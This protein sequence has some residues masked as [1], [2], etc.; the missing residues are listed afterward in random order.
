MS[1]RKRL[2]KFCSATYSPL[3]VRER[4]TGWDEDILS[5]YSNRR[6]HLFKAN[7]LQKNKHT[8]ENTCCIWCGNDIAWLHGL[9]SVQYFYELGRFTCGTG[10]I[11]ET[12]VKTRLIRDGTPT[13]SI[14]CQYYYLQHHVYCQMIQAVKTKYY[15]LKKCARQ[16][17]YPS[18]TRCLYVNS[19]NVDTGWISEIVLKHTPEL[20]TDMEY[21]GLR[22][23]FN[24][25]HSK[26]LECKRKQWGN[27]YA[28]QI[29]NIAVEWYN[30]FAGLNLNHGYSDISSRDGVIH[31]LTRTYK[32]GLSF[33]YNR[34]HF[35]TVNEFYLSKVQSLH[36]KKSSNREKVKIWVPSRTKNNDGKYCEQ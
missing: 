11:F 18:N 19:K 3:D 8:L 17:M 31:L 21:G 5:A 36:T 26:R 13:C 4:I 28:N 34:P 30:G 24:I 35:K 15:P 9:K 22:T 1:K 7:Y 16:K 32:K 10:N 25:W 23:M 20:L 6:L 2:A 12:G 29:M 33:M 27:P 14:N